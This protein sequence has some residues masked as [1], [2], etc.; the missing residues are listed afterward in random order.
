MVFDGP[1]CGC[2]ML[3]EQRSPGS[4]AD[5]G[6]T[7]GGTNDVGKE[8]CHEHSVDIDAARGGCSGDELGDRVKDWVIIAGLATHVKIAWDIDEASTCDVIGQV[9]TQSYGNDR[10]AGA[11]HDQCRDT[12]STEGVADIHVH[13]VMQDRGRSSR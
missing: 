11:V 3:F 4:I 12:H 5:R 7:G 6:G 8:H 1:F 9:S 13:V 2:I 10:I